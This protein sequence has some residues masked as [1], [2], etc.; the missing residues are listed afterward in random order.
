MY[1]LCS[2]PS[3]LFLSLSLP[4]SLALPVFP[5]DILSAPLLTSLPVPSHVYSVCLHSVTRKSRGHLLPDPSVRHSLILVLFFNSLCPP[6][7]L[8]PFSPPS[9]GRHIS[10]PLD[11]SVASEERG[12]KGRIVFPIHVLFREELSG[13]LFCQVSP[14]AL[15]IYFFP[16]RGGKNVSFVW[17]G[18]SGSADTAGLCIRPGGHSSM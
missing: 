6:P 18:W 7:P 13:G 12:K 5:I 4:L 1:S 15:G 14:L 9:E 10:P 11:V 8:T 16:P 2:S 3:F 17:V